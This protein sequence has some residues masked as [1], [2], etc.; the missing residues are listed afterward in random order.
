M[1]VRLLVYGIVQGVGFRPFVMALA[2][3]WN[4]S[5]TVCNTGSSVCIDL[6]GE[7]SAIAAFRKD[8]MMKAPKGSRILGIRE[9]PGIA[10]GRKDFCILPSPSAGDGKL[11]WISPDLPTCPACLAEMKD[12]RNRRFRHAFIS[13]TACGPRY[14]IL[15]R[16]PYDRENTA[17]DTFPMCPQCQAEYARD[18]R[19]KHAQTIACPHCGPV[20]CMGEHTGEEAYQD[21]VRCIREGKLVAIKGIG[22]YQIVVKPDLQDAVRQL[23]ECKGREKKPFAVM[24]ADVDQI[25]QYVPVSSEEEELLT[26]AARP[27]VL[28]EGKAFSEEVDGCSPDVGAF[29]PYSPLHHRLVEELG[30]LIVTS[31]NRSSD[32][33]AWDTSMV[34]PLG[35]PILD[36]DRPIETPLDDSVVRISAGK[37]LLIRRSRGYVPLPVILSQKFLPE[38]VLAMGGD[39]KACF[40]LAL[41][42]H[43]YP[44]QYLGD[45]ENPFVQEL[46]V[47]TLCRM[48][49]ILGIHP[50][51]VVTD[52]HPGY[53][54]GRLAH[55]LFPDAKHMS[56]Q[57]HHAHVASVMAEHGLSHSIGIAFDGTG[58]GTDHSIWGGEF[59]WCQEDKMERLAYLEPVS[60]CGG[61]AAVKNARLGLQSYLYAAELPVEEP[62]IRTA[63]MKEQ[64]TVPTSSMG[65]LF[66]AVSALLG[67]C[68]HNQYEGQ[69]PTA[70][71]AAARGYHG[72]GYD[73][74]EITMRTDGSLEIVPYFRRLAEATWKGVE[75]ARL[76]WQFHQDLVWMTVRACEQIRKVTGENNVAVSGGVFVNRILLEGCVRSLQK[77]GFAVYWNQQVPCNDGGICLGQAW[78][79][80]QREGK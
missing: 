15:K 34:K 79:A 63:L 32:P 25:R 6:A 14:S 42:D 77:Q 12:P 40:A 57:H 7:E 33:I 49:A 56:F 23:R 24:F 80:A 43:V 2:Q 54:T 47:E 29:L 74:G 52:L 76:A 39:L 58:Y 59:L 13:C 66:D 18:P 69:C 17:M 78:L 46:F 11:P 20:L 60:F 26:S 55:R 37:P 10:E 75:P 19:R 27:I 22:G 62:L 68:T 36:H 38:G 35:L 3:E 8:L 44:S 72:G 1:T 16:L 51:K 73:L 64:G 28:I 70:L 9:L 30:P 45:M 5:G 21:A 71:E 61:N 67:I 50:Q 48:E 4:L 65:R 41:E 31:A 53:E